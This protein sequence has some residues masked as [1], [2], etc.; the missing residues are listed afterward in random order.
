M[1]LIVEKYTIIT[2]T[3]ETIIITVKTVLY[4]NNNL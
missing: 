3:F 1:K 4:R 2:I